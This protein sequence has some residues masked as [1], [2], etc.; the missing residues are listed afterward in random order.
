MCFD[1]IFLTNKI[2][3]EINM[4]SHVLKKLNMIFNF[5][6][7]THKVTVTSYILNNLAAK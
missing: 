1:D 7:A 6:F 3:F 4:V 5:F 2:F